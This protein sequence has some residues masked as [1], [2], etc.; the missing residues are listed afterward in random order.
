MNTCMTRENM[1]DAAAK[2]ALE[3]RLASAGREGPFTRV[4]IMAE[5]GG[6]LP[7]GERGELVIRSGSIM[8]EYYK[9]RERS[10]QSRLFG[11]HHTGDVGF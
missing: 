10:E 3:H 1:A 9:D 4:A 8:R 2:P 6:L 7:A 5:D 11:W